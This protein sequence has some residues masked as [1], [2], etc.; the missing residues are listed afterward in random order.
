MSAG[1]PGWREVLLLA[2]AVVVGVL[3]VQVVSELVPPVG[4]ALASY[5]VV[6]VVLVAVTAL[7][8]AAA[9]RPRRG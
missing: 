4:A 8:I 3:A 1:E 5:P 7:L 6:I 9:L 2:V